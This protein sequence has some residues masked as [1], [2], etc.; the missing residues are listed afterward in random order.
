MRTLRIPFGPLTR[1]VEDNALVLSVIAGHDPKD[2]LTGSEAVPDYAASLN[3]DLSGVRIGIVRELSRDLELHPDVQTAFD[4]ALQI[5]GRARRCYTRYH[6]RGLS[7]A[8]HSK[9][10]RRMQKL[11]LC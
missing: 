6:C 1:T 10:L 2:P 4:T 3:G 5:L 8:Y 7:I 11:L 9:C